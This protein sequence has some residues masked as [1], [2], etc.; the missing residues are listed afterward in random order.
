MITDCSSEFV[1]V[2]ND[3]R[4][5]CYTVSILQSLIESP[6]MSQL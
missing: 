2:L 6:I 5:N 4:A 3:Y 1:T